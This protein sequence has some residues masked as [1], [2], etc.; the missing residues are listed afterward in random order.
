VHIDGKVALI[1]RPSD[2]ELAEKLLTANGISVLS[3]EELKQ[4]FK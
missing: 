1:I 2:V 3:L 4:D